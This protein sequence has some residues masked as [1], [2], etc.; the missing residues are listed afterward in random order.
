MLG[1]PRMDE[2]VSDLLRNN[3]Q[4]I[5]TAVRERQHESLPRSRHADPVDPLDPLDPVTSPVRRQR[6]R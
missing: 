5:K 4:Q 3:I 1:D 2:L 6:W